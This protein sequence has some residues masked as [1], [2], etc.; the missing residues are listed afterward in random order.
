MGKKKVAGKSVPRCPVSGC[1]T[2]LSEE[3]KAKCT[4][5]GV[6]VCQ[7]HVYPADHFCM[8]GK[9]KGSEAPSDK[10]AGDGGLLQ[11]VKSDSKKEDKKQDKKKEEELLSKLVAAKSEDMLKE[12]AT[13]GSSSSRYESSLVVQAMSS[14]SKAV[15]KA[16]FGAI[17]A[18]IA[19]AAEAAGSLKE[20]LGL[21]ETYLKK[22]AGSSLSD[23]EERR[24]I[25]V[26]NMYGVFLEKSGEDAM[27]N[28]DVLDLG[29]AASRSPSEKVAR[30]VATEIVARAA[31]KW[32]N[33]ADYEASVKQLLLDLL[34]EGLSAGESDDAV[35]NGC[36]HSAAAIANVVGAVSCGEDVSSLLRPVLDSPKDTAKVLTCMKATLLLCKDMGMT[37]TPF[38]VRGDWLNVGVF[39]VYEQAASSARTA[40][41]K[42]MLAM[43]DKLDP[44]G[45]RLGVPIL[46]NGLEDPSWRAKALSLQLLGALGK[47]KASQLFRDLPLIIP[48]VMDC[49]RDTKK[50]V[51]EA[52]ADSLDQLSGMITNAET[53]NLMP[54]LLDALKNPEKVELC[55]DE[56]MDTT[57]VNSVDAQSLAFIIPVVLRG[58]REGSAEVKLK[59]SI[60]AGNVCS[61]VADVHDM[62]PFYPLLMPELKK[63]QEHSRP[64][65]RENAL[66]AKESL[67]EDLGMTR[68]RSSHDKQNNCI[69]SVEATQHLNKV[70]GSI[71]ETSQ[72]GSL[73]NEY[74]VET[75]RMFLFDLFEDIDEQMPRNLVMKQV[76]VLVKEGV[77]PLLSKGLKG[78]DNVS[79]IGNKVAEAIVESL[80][81]AQ[82]KS[83][84]SGNEVASEKEYLVYLPSIILAFAS[85][86]LL[87]RTGLFLEK[88]HR[89]SIVGRNGVGK[90]TM[91]NR[92][93]ARDINGFPSDVSCY[94]VQHEIMEEDASLSVAGYMARD[95]DDIVNSS[96]SAKAKQKKQEHEDRI[97]KAK[98][99][100][101]KVGFS[102]ELQNK[103]VASL[104][105]GWRMRLAIARSMLYNANLLLLDEPT[106]HLDVG[107]LDWL[108][109]YL[110]GLSETTIVFVSHDYEFVEFVATDIIHIAD[111]KLTYHPYG[112]SE[113]KTKR[114]DIVDGLP[115]KD[116]MDGGDNSGGDNAF[117]LLA[118]SAAGD[119]KA[120]AMVADIKPMK[121]PEGCKL[122]GVANRGRPVAEISDVTYSYPGTDKV[123]F[124]NVAARLSLNSR[125]ALKGPNGA[126]KTTLLKLL[127]GELELDEEHG[128]TGKVWKHHNL[129]TA[130]IAQHSMHHLEE[131]IEMTPCQYIQKR[132]W[133]GQDRE[134]AKMITVNLTPEDE[135]LMQEVGEISEIVSRVS[136]SKKLF[137]E[138]KK[139]GRTEKGD[140]K[141]FRS[142]DDLERMSKDKPYILKLVRL[143]D[144]KL[145]IA[146]SGADLR[147]LTTPEM[148]KHLEDFG[149]DSELS[150]R[151]IRW[152]SGGQKCRLVIAAAMWTRPHL[153]VLDEPTNYLDRES[154]AALTFSLKT[155][156]GGVI[157][158]SHHTAF[159]DV[160]AKEIWHFENGGVRTEMLK[161][162]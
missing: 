112:F 16:F 61:L 72:L 83:Q 21:L 81:I 57:F 139:N 110:A 35:R 82:G 8:T 60:T 123:I 157:L 15:S 87:K 63:L 97:S 34:N 136:R 100:L 89:Y 150:Q 101:D 80:W 45:V 135:E 25:S 103:P 23:Q 95:L 93:A 125:V 141:D 5:C 142:L 131:S 134:S 105:G 122:S 162:K 67:Q 91:L 17:S 99:A 117:E 59:A 118:R 128:D 47:R 13:F 62:R 44:R 92:I 53:I 19:D 74:L 143:F 104:S 36:V 52:A 158:I 106:N 130:Y 12:L 4:K 132:F 3:A 127:V 152:M 115:K 73:L 90:T 42:A 119:E 68:R 58:L 29:L 98:E 33:G 159:V 26:A 86:M 151:K 18:G 32:A 64:R 145:K 43:M 114:P 133:E 9:T 51:S 94:Y 137:Y 147:P 140:N 31:R 107:A 161:D 155:F 76:V 84:G 2:Q 148:I 75:C 49:V 146:D 69:V 102:E 50:Q 154:L 120:A 144:E 129:R 88:G 22:T 10:A 77:V 40:T 56:L 108:Q 48:A 46:L 121:F 39:S 111:L 116:A 41:K 124:K 7:E 71:P 55:L 78:T 11:V 96:K 65:V 28:K 138:I 1:K 54:W 109:N 153:L 27:K 79:Q 6:W 24:T 37:Y 149:I 113:F 70:L 160:L 126:G 14:E 156:R 20:N 38:L 85:R 66:K 30:A